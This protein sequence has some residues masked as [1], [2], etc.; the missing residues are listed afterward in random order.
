VVVV[1]PSVVPCAGAPGVVFFF[2][3]VA[4]DFLVA[5]AFAFI[6]IIKVG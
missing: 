4:V 3:G 6:A 2:D 5:G 1:M